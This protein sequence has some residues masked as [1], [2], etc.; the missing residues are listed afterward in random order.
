MPLRFWELRITMTALFKNDLNK[1]AEFYSVPL[2]F[3]QSLD[4][5]SKAQAPILFQT[6]VDY[7]KLF[8]I[9]CAVAYAGLSQVL[10]VLGTCEI[11]QQ[12]RACLFATF[13]DFSPS[14]PNAV[15]IT[16]ISFI[17]ALRFLGLWVVFR[18]YFNHAKCVRRHLAVVHISATFHA[19]SVWPSESCKI[20]IFLSAQGWVFAHVNTPRIHASEI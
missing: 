9:L 4:N 20:H 15:I 7:W 2:L 5:N 17:I 18:A 8:V 11:V 13:K 1:K 12:G 6:D 19:V 10:E 14:T 16:N 3:H